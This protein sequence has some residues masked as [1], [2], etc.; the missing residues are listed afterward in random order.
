MIE[1]W[2]INS[3]V[4]SITPLVYICIYQYKDIKELKKFNDLKDTYIKYLEDK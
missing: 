1:H 3:L 2:I 4:F